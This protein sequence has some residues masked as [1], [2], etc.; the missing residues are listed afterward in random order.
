M[1]AYD[2]WTN[3]IT[4]CNIV[5]GATSNSRKLVIFTSAVIKLYF[6]FFSLLS[7]IEISK[8]ITKQNEKWSN[9]KNC[10]SQ[11]FGVR[12]LNYFHC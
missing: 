8:S 3:S 4:P 2:S 5:F 10:S 12:V 11:T 9:N 1:Y 7:L 6:K